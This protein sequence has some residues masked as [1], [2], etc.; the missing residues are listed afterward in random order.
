MRRTYPLCRLSPE[1][2]GQLVH[3]HARNQKKLQEAERLL[4]AFTF[5]VRNVLGPEAVWSLQAKARN[6][7][8]LAELQKELR[9]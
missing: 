8:A 7:I 2:A 3:E 9:A 6:T 5:E 1:A 4:A